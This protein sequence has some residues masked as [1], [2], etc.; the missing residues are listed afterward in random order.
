VRIAVISEFLPKYDKIVETLLFIA[1]KCSGID[2]YRTVKIMYLADKLHF[3]KYS[4]PITFDVYF[5]F[6]NGPVGSNAYDL[7]KSNQYALRRAK[8]EELPIRLEKMD[9]LILMKEPMRAINYDLF[10]KSDVKILEN[11]IDEYAHKTFGEIFD[12]THEHFAYQNAWGNRIDGQKRAPMKYIDLMEDGERKAI[13]IEE[14][15]PVSNFVR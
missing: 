11:V 8:I 3:E 12:E 10:S 4:R 2:Q 5:A 13:Y 1:H 14:K 6:K 15:L 7:L 9:N